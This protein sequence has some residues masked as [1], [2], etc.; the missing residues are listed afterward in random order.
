M[1]SIIFSP[2][3]LCKGQAIYDNLYASRL[4]M[5]ETSER[6][7]TL[8]ALRQQGAINQTIDLLF[9]HG[10]D[11]EA[12]KLFAITYLAMQITYFSELDRDVANNVSS[13]I[14]MKK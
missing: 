7:K 3:Y 8:A 6:A 11:T 4:V 9:T 14:L 13:R 12:I 5:C 1:T 2:E 10:P